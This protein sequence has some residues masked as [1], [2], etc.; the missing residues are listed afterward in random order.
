MWSVGVVLYVMLCGYT[1]FSDEDQERMFE[2]IK[3]GDWKFESKDWAHVSKEAKDLIQHCMCPTVDKR[4]TA[5]QA[6]KSP[7][8][9]G[10]TDKQLSSNDLSFTSKTIKNRKPKLSDIASVFMAFRKK[11]AGGSS[12]VAS[13]SLNNRSTVRPNESTHSP[14]TSSIRHLV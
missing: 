5:A 3:L 8:I 12:S 11:D 4:M 7:W 14:T 2:R 1:P 13:S 9:I 6:L 10:L